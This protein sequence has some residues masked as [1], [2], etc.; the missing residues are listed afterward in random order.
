[1]SYNLF[2]DDIRHPEDAYAYT[3]FTPFIKETWSIVRNYSEFV[4]II[5]RRGLPSFIA[6]D[7]D[8]S[9]E[10]YNVPFDYWNDTSS[11][12]LRLEETGFDCAK[13]LINYCIDNNSELPNFYVHSMNPVG[14]KN[15]ESLLFN[16]IKFKSN[17]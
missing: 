5:K 3:H 15:I 12:D 14:K 6:F 8:L 4:S 1:M 9:D 10:H 11:E 13:W 2:L 17:E 7:H 16:Y